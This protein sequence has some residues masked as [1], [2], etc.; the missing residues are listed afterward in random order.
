[1]NKNKRKT[2]LIE[3]L[4]ELEL[5]VNTGINKLHSDKKTIIKKN[6][7]FIPKCC[8]KIIY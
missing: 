6:L 5:M 4:V 2:A 7:S 3:E 1:M 8:M